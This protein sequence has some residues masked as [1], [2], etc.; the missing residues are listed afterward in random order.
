MGLGF[1]HS[2]RRQSYGPSANELS[3]VSSKKLFTVELS[4]G[5]ADRPDAPDS[6]VGQISDS[7]VPVVVPFAMSVY[8]GTGG[9]L[10]AGILQTISSAAVPDPSVEVNTESFTH[11]AAQ[12]GPTLVTVTLASLPSKEVPKSTTADEMQFGLDSV[13]APSSIA[14]ITI[15][16]TAASTEPIARTAAAAKLNPFEVADFKVRL[17]QFVFA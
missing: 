10:G 9:E 12:S 1:L 7:E 14:G 17:S 11:F 8:E 4:I 13:P 16:V 6:L 15:V 2:K 5:V 3:E